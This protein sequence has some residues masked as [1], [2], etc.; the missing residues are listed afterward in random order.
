MRYNYSQS[1]AINRC[2]FDGD[3]ANFSTDG[4]VQ[5]IQ[6][7]LNLPISRSLVVE[8]RRQIKIQAKK[9]WNQYRIDDYAYRM[10]FLERLNKIKRVEDSSMAKM[11]EYENEPKKFFHWRQSCSMLLEATKQ[12]TELLMIFPEIDTVGHEM[13]KQAEAVRA[14][15]Y[16]E[17]PGNR[18]F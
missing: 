15:S 12:I 18:Q 4:I 9:T 1:V 11:L 14:E 16:R 2:I 10:E 13:D 8:R 3:L 5:L 6:D 17:D 7:R